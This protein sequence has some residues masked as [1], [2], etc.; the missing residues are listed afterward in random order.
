MKTL[1]EDGYADVCLRLVGSVYPQDE[2]YAAGLRQRVADNGL[3]TAVEFVGGMTQD[4]NA[5]KA[6]RCL[7]FHGVTGAGKNDVDADASGGEFRG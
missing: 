4:G 6:R 1:R 3:T 5:L 7:S 2:V